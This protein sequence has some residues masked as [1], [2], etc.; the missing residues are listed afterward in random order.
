MSWY[1]ADLA[2]VGQ[3][4]QVDGIAGKQNKEKYRCPDNLANPVQELK[5]LVP[6]YQKVGGSRRIGEHICL[7]NNRSKS[8]FHLM[9]S[10]SMLLEAK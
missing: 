10:I 3:A 7:E 9:R 8:F 2:A 6:Q 5:R 4:F 1:L